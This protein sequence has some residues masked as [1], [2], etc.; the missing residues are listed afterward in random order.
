MICKGSG[1][2]WRGITCGKRILGLNINSDA[3][4]FLDS[5][6]A[7]TNNVSRITLGNVGDDAGAILFRGRWGVFPGET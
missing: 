6:Q 3:A 4:D 1:G 7:N 5:A 2:L